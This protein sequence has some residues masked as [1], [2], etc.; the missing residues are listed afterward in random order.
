MN[1]SPLL[2]ILIPT[3][4]RAKYL[5]FAIQSALNIPED[6]IE[7]LVSE[8]HSVDNSFEILSQFT[9]PRL[10]IFRPPSPLPMH[11]NWEFLLSKSSGDW[12]YFLGDDDAIMPHVVTYLSR[13]VQKYPQLEALVTPRA[14][15]FW[16][17]VQSIYGSKCLSINF[18]SK[19]VWMDSKKMLYK[20]LNGKEDYIRLPQLYSGGFQRRILINRIKH[21]QSG[22]YFK[23]TIPDAYSALAA[24]LHTF[25][26]LETGVPL[27]WVGSSPSKE[28]NK[29]HI[30][31]IKE[32]LADFKGMHTDDNLTYNFSLGDFRDITFNLCFYE[33]YLSAFP[34]TNYS[35]M[36][37]SKLE[38]V[39]YDF[40]YKKGKY[41]NST[42]LLS[43]KIGFNVPN[44]FSLK[45]NYFMLKRIAYNISKK[46]LNAYHLYQNKEFFFETN[47]HTLFPNILAFDATLT[48][49]LQS[50]EKKRV[51]RE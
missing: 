4:N 32:R 13:I 3:R 35:L 33:A 51:D 27:A 42:K 18:S 17:G 44:L 26:Y 39:F 19:E 23:S 47:D 21:S 24:V 34:N 41:S 6:N 46:I 31:I 10:T 2:S 38:E 15:Y 8:N 7:I 48:E 28:S 45:Y 29:S 49:M 16:D 5:K 12:I 1:K 36:S 50:F 22:V 30:H 9:D 20:C 37:Q 25:R 40:C 43:E 11:E 14:Y